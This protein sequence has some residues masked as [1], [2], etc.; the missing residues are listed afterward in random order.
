MA[1]EDLS[2]LKIEKVRAISRPRRRKKIIYLSL[3]MIAIMVLGWL[4][5]KGFFTPAIEVQVATITQIYP[6]QTFTVLNASGYVVPQRKAA[7][8]SKVTGRLVWLGVEE[9]NRI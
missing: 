6:S 1:N 2:R 8:A 9:G 3:A 5:A 4:Y 7:L